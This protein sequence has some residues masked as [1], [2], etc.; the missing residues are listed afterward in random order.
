[1]IKSDAS[2]SEDPGQVNNGGNADHGKVADLEELPD[3]LPLDLFVIPGA[4]IRSRPGVAKV[5]A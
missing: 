4:Q 3:L 2:V 1:V 5:I